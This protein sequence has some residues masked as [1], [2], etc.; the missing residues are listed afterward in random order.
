M[1]KSKIMTF[2]NLQNPVYNYIYTYNYYGNYHTLLYEGTAIGFCVK[3]KNT[4]WYLH[5][6]Q[7]CSKE[8]QVATR[9]IVAI[10]SHKSEESF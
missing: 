7:D 4:T 5:V 1:S 8:T 10:I 3:L 2:G 9:D 6:H